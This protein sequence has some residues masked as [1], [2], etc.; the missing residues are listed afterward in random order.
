MA[1]H[2]KTAA[3]IVATVLGPRGIPAKARIA[4]LT[5]TM[6]AIVTK[7]VAPPRISRRRVV[8]RSATRKNRTRLIAAPRG[9]LPPVG[10]VA[11]PTPRS[12]GDRNRRR[13]LPVPR[14][15]LEIQ[16]NDRPI[17]VV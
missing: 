1:R 11:A 14:E 3:R 15:D 9:P 2:P 17:S 7:V 4:G 5:T 16:E 6:Y 10:A 13:A 8:P 12:P